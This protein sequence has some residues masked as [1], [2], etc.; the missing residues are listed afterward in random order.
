MLYDDY[1]AY[2]S[3]YTQK[4]GERV[5]VLM[6]V[7]S[8]FEFYAVENDT[9][10]E[11]ASIGDL[12][13]LLNIQSTRKNKSI[14]NCSRANPLMAGFPSYS[15]P[16]FIDLLLADHYT[17]VLVEQTTPPP[18]PQRAVTQVISP[19]TYLGTSGV[20][21]GVS[22]ASSSYLMCVYITTVRSRSGAG[23][24]YVVSVA[25]MDLSTGETF[26]FDT[27]RTG[28]HTFPAIEL[29]RL[30]S[31]YAPRELVLIG[32][33]CSVLSLPLPPC[34]ILRGAG[35]GTGT[36]LAPFQRP[37]YQNAVL[38]KVYPHTGLLTPIEYVQLEQ[39]AD[40]L[41][42]F[43]YLIQ[44]AYEHNENIIAKLQ[45]PR[46]VATQSHLRLA[47]SSAEQLYLLPKHGVPSSVLQLLNT[48]DTAMGRRFFRDCLVHPLCDASRIDERY[49][50]SDAV[51]PHITPLRACLKGIKDLERLFRRIVLRL[52]QPPEI[53]VL[54]DSL[55]A[56]IQLVALIN[57]KGLDMETPS[58][59]PIVDHCTRRWDMSKLDT[60]ADHFYQR[61]VYPEMDALADTVEAHHGMFQKVVDDANRVVGDAFFKLETTA[62]RHDYQIIITKKRYETYVE[63]TKGQ[64]LSPVFTVQPVSASNKTVLKATFPKMDAIQHALHRHTG[65]LRR[66]VHDQYLLDLDALHVF[67]DAMQTAVAFVSAIDFH[68]TCA[69]NAHTFR[70]CR[71]TVEATATAS[72]SFLRGTGLRHPLIE[73]VQTDLPY[74]ANDIALGGDSNPSG[75]LLYGIN[76]AGKSSYMKSVGLALIMAQA[77]MYVAADTFA[78]SPYDHIFTRIPGGDNLFKGQS[79]FVAEISELR[80]ILNEGT[81]RSLVI[82]DE[83]ASGTESVSA[84]SIVAAGVKTLA[85]RHASFIF[86]T[87]LHE[88]AQ[89]AV[90]QEL[91]NVAIFH[92]SVHY[93]DARGVL[94]YDRLLKPGCGETLYGLE[95]C[96]SLDMPLAF[97][98]LAHTIRKEHLHLSPTVVDTKVSRYS[99]EVFVDVCSV[100]HQRA[101]EVH[102]I[103]HQARADKDGFIGRMHKN[104]A[105]NLVALCQTC[106]DKVHDNSMQMDG[107]VQTSTGKML[108]INPNSVNIIDDTEMLKKQI[109]GKDA[110]QKL[111]KQGKSYKAIAEELKLTVYEVRKHL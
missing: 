91:A 108:M 9:I 94:V 32:D 70:Y 35:V 111:R 65:D 13:S 62:E 105:H 61:G 7:G 8:F 81:H 109:E 85:D 97:M 79:T 64:T 19:A 34:C 98:Q 30:V 6:E 14:P 95:V 96:K 107:V 73:V 46:L 20:G 16:K 55:Q 3:T 51:R 26:L 44:F 78:F 87:H 17:I 58:V 27:E 33:G 2:C 11:G 25:Y 71:P 28:D 100:C 37:V 102:H 80:T 31:L 39:R 67:A 60:N 29:V 92:I 52:A 86:A 1:I 69:K 4:Y 56:I 38:K 88:V 10:K 110:V 75:I 74:I 59:Q 90:I 84:I 5:V 21:G 23:N 104:D 42:A 63:K 12:C 93:D 40:A 66:V 18:N 76:A 83:L 103:Q 68:V 43:V 82:G 45:R 53:A 48:C 50:R 99:S 36:D 22:G 54:V 24:L 41:T 77:G 57:D 101:E 49:R 47:H 89:L 106:H 15:L 72:P